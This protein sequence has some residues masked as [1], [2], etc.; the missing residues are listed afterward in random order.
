MA[1]V[2]GPAYII[3]VWASQSLGL[4]FVIFMELPL[5][6]YVRLMFYCFGRF[7]VLKERMP[8]VRVRGERI[9]IHYTV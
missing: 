7:A 9:D 1:G 5:S 3:A 4:I 2:A 8:G 6:E